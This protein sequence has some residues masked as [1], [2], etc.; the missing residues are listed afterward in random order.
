MLADAALQP[1]HTGRVVARGRRHSG[2][3][4]ASRGGPSVKAVCRIIGVRPQYPTPVKLGK[5][6]ESS[7]PSLHSTSLSAIKR[8]VS[9]LRGRCDADEQGRVF[10]D[11][12]PESAYQGGNPGSVTSILQ[13]GVISMLRL[14]N[15]DA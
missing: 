14:D 6:G 13:R 8:S 10:A 12:G 1:M 4:G 7:I 11:Q 3:I 9:G 15:L 2:R 5:Q